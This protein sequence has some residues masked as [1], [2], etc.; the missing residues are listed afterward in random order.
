MVV[1]LVG[2]GPGDP[3]LI[4]IKAKRLIKKA[5]VLIYDRLVSDVIV[6]WAPPNCK[7]IYMGKHNEDSN[8][9]QQI[10]KDIISILL[11]YGRNQNV[12]RLKGGDPFIFGRGGEEA[13]ACVNESIKFEIVPG[14]SSFYA[15]AA[16]SG[17]PVSH[18]DFNSVFAVLTGHESLKAKS[19]ID[20]SKLPETIII[21]MGVS[22]I[23]EI[24]KNL[25]ATG[26]D[27]E[28]PVAAVEWGTTH[29]QKTLITT[30]GN[31]ASGI[32]GLNPPTVFIIGY[33]VKLH[34]SLNW[35]EKKMKAASGKKVVLTRARSHM[36]ESEKIL[37]AYD[38]EPII[39]PLI[40]I[41]SRDFRIPKISDYDC[42]LYTSPSPRDRS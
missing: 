36:V 11:K 25:L 37:K 24:A 28:T 20:W 38:I 32:E 42:L 1:Y 3:E 14:V 6:S 31:L 10:Q 8:I 5:E 15:A 30:L 40:E 39:M 17:I 41:V 21:L 29:K 34:S 35:F 13:L 22:K 4:T 33:I 2:A 18:R 26:R 7:L 9:S 27:N 23:Q 16:Y 12:V 19:T